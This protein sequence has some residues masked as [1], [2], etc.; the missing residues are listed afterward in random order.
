MFAAHPPY[1]RRSTL[2]HASRQALVAL[3]CSAQLMAWTPTAWAQ[4]NDLPALG[5]PASE[6]LSVAGEAR[7]GQQ[8]M[9][10][11]HRDADVIEDPQL[12]D[13]ID[14]LWQPLLMAARTR[15]EITP[16]LDAHYAWTPFLVRDRSVN[17]FALPGG[18]IGVHLGLIAM[19]A[20]RDELASV[21]AH[22][23]SHVT[24]RHIARRMGA[25]KTSS[26]V[27][28]LSIVLGLLAVTR[29]PNAANA[30]IMGGQAAAAQ[31]QLNFSRDMEREADR[32]G[33]GVLTQAGFAPEGMTAMFD[34]LQHASRLVDSQQYP[35]LR[36]HPLTTERIGEA[37]ARLGPTEHLGATSGG[38]SAMW[39]HALMRGRAKALMDP[40]IDEQNRLIEQQP[41]AQETGPAALT[42]AYSAAM[43]A[44]KQHQFAAAE[45][46]L[47]QA[48]QLVQSDPVAQAA[49][50]HALDYLHVELL[51]E[52]QRGAQAQA[53]MA[54]WRPDQSRPA[55]LLKAQA[56]LVSP[57]P[58]AQL[59]P[60][61][62]ELR[63]WLAEHTTDA[64][65]WQA[66]AQVEER[67]GFMLSS[68]RA[69]AEARW[70]EGD[71]R[72]ATEKMRAAQQWARALPH[73]SATDFIE[74]SIIDSRLKQMSHELQAERADQNAGT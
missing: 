60:L 11:L 72:G 28:A 37:R 52:N 46:A 34:Q 2:R 14:S 10:A 67:R 62:E 44:M 40:R 18:H 42:R 71:H 50:G 68:L 17:A 38:A 19:T 64:A 4:H 30:M 24:Q 9:Q 31:G 12:L 51:I 1:R 39:L 6:D 21:L 55:L 49:V 45:T 66:L 65:A 27:G 74:L 36:S 61:S 23:L 56:L 58:V 35:Y 25:G 59:N 41:V 57:G 26:M 33:F 70:H 29:S 16:E 47:A 8:I 73:M 22:E 63:L 13:Y 32:I 43:A 7:L 48:R 5:D 3:L 53:A 54:L 20:S 69:Q 15:G